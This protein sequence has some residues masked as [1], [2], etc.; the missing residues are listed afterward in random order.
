M[1][2]PTSPSQ[3][4]HGKGTAELATLLEQAQS[5]P[6]GRRIESRDPIAAF[7]PLAIEGVRP[8]LTDDALAAF[9]VR[10]IEKVGIDGEAALATE[11][12]RAA[13]KRVP[14][15]V[16][17]DVEWALERLKAASRP[18]PAPA[19]TPAAAAPRPAPRASAASR[20]RTR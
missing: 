18:A 3:P 4:D 16:T 11:A 17:G 12:L 8:W 5:A 19:P 1:Q 20:R 9:A 2:K 15:A 10:V 13:R 14:E 7:G 6:P